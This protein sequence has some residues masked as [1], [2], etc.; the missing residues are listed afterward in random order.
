MT[1]A[2]VCARPA[3]QTDL[4]LGNPLG[5]LWGVRCRYGSSAAGTWAHRGAFAQQLP[6]DRVRR[7]RPADP[8]E[9]GTPRAFAAKITDVVTDPKGHLQTFCTLAALRVA[10]TVDMIATGT[11]VK[12]LEWAFLIRDVRSAQ[13]SS[14]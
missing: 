3:E 8:Q 2:A 7:R 6:G 1:R 14:R 4:A 12:P 9:A 13:T 11:D 5:N 10:V